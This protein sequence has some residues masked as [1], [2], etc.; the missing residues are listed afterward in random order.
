MLFVRAASV[1]VGLQLSDFDNLAGEATA[2]SSAQRLIAQAAGGGVGLADYTIT[3][4]TSGIP[5]LPPSPPPLPP[6]P[7]PAASS[8][9]PVVAIAG[10]AAGGIAL[11]AAMLWVRTRTE[12][13]K[14]TKM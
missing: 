13:R 9:S 2:A 6:P 4:A 3:G 5:P 8:A 1:E 14:K 11:L 12:K 10:G 7:P